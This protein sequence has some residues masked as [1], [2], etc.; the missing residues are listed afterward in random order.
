MLIFYTDLGKIFL[1]AAHSAHTPIIRSSA[2]SAGVSKCMLNIVVLKMLY[3][4]SNTVVIPI[5]ITMYLFKVIG[6]I[7]A[8]SKNSVPKIMYIKFSV[9]S[10]HHAVPNTDWSAVGPSMLNRPRSARTTKIKPT[11]LRNCFG[12]MSLEYH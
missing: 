10:N 8:K 5:A 4:P 12:F 11:D 3:K 9:L 6:S 1:G 7:K 2:E